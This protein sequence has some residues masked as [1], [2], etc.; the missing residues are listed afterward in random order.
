MT[1][2]GIEQATFQFV[3]QHLSHCATAVPIIYGTGANTTTEITGRQA[4][5]R[6]IMCSEGH[7]GRV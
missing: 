7:S 4:A 6:N 3:A 1:P 2:S 5:E